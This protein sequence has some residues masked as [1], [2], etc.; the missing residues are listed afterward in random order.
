MYFT[1]LDLNDIF[2]F[3]ENVISLWFYIKRKTPVIKL[4]FVVLCHEIL[5]LQRCIHNGYYLHN[6]VPK[7]V[8]CTEKVRKYE[9]SLVL[10]VPSLEQEPVLVNKINKAILLQ[11]FMKIFFYNILIVEE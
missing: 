7:A 8:C 11:N 3:L 9:Y 2:H 1:D 6:T 4:L 5:L 10:P